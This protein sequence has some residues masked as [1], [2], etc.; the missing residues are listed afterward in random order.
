MLAFSFKIENDLS[1]KFTET[2]EESD[3]RLNVAD[4]SSHENVSDS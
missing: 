1:I 2:L 3:R 4:T